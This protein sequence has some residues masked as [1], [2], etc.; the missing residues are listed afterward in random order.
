[1]VSYF[2]VD[3]VL[4]VNLWP[5]DYP[6]LRVR[7][8]KLLTREEKVPETVEE[9][10]EWSCLLVKPDRSDLSFRYVVVHAPGIG[11]ALPFNPMQVVMRAQGIVRGM[12]I[13]GT[14]TWNRSSGAVKSA[15]KARQ[16]VILGGGRGHDAFSA[17]RQCLK[18][19]VD[20]IS[21][22]LG[23]AVRENSFD[24]GEL[25]LQ[26]QVFT[27]NASRGKV[28]CALP[29]S[30]PDYRAVRGMAEY[31]YVK[32][33]LDIAR[34]T[35]TGEVVACTAA[36]VAI[37]DLVDVS[38]VIEVKMTENGEELKIPQ[39]Q[40]CLRQIV[41]LKKHAQG[42]ADLTCAYTLHSD[43]GVRI[44]ASFS[45]KRKSSYGGHRDGSKRR[46]DDS[47]GRRPVDVHRN[48]L[49][50]SRASVRQNNSLP[51]DKTGVP[52]SHW[53]RRSDRSSG[54]S[55]D[56][57]QW[58]VS[59]A[60]SPSVT[61]DNGS[62]QSVATSFGMGELE[63]GE[64]VEH[65]PASIRD[66]G[67]MAD[68]FIRSVSEET[69]SAV[70]H[71]GSSEHRHGEKTVRFADSVAGSRHLG[72][73]AVLAHGPL[74]RTLHASSGELYKGANGSPLSQSQKSFE[75]ELK[76]E[77]GHGDICVERPIGIDID[78]N[79]PPSQAVKRIAETAR[80]DDEGMRMKAGCQRSSLSA[81]LAPRW[82]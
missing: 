8:P 76:S 58:D 14:G 4:L 53:E 19:F 45:E 56:N 34:Q 18:N 15:E 26:R 39:V 71:D 16:F 43:D 25:Y 74:P 42:V 64:I 20:A 7:D 48:I 52:D 80:R 2:T 67:D 11:K 29:K 30:D 69:K 31:W 13:R 17:Q 62:T 9:L 46:R 77:A 65:L 40:Y 55:A 50:D 33:S 37:G 57:L 38:M 82:D 10:L 78:W 32:D 59:S 5:G 79:A 70:V 54:S 12:D 24:K 6:Q 47:Y 41:V 72:C 68:V 35:P 81:R 49:Y 21:Q 36:E 60:C 61:S 73:N 27:K 66:Y 44:N 75:V 22:K 3:G 28:G 63:P 1:M 23:R 51:S